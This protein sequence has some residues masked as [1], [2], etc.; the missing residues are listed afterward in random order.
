MLSGNVHAP[1]ATDIP[2]IGPFDIGKGHEGYL[3]ASPS[4][5]TYVIEKLTGG[6]VGSSLDD[7]RKDIEEADPEVIKEQFQWALDYAKNC[8]H[9]PPKDFWGCLEPEWRKNAG[10]K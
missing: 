1:I 2:V 3:A 9:L 6:I 10:S 4:G 7:V 8:D 5:K